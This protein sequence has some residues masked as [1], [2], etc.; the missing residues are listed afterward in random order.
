MAKEDN[1][2][3]YYCQATVAGHPELTMESAI[4]KYNVTCMYELTYRVDRV[5]RVDNY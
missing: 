3:E 2:A 5:D 1:Q 4:K